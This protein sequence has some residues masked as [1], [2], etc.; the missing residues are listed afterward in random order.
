MKEGK[1]AALQTVLREEASEPKS[2]VYMSILKLL[3]PTTLPY[4]WG[5]VCRISL[6][7]VQDVRNDTMIAQ[8]KT[9]ESQ[10]VICF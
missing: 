7:M 5:V 9:I 10:F 3:S 2:H 1:W 4:G 8:R 6:S